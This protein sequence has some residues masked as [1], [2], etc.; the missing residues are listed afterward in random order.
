MP[1][2]AT[3]SEVPLA[4]GGQSSRGCIRREVLG[5]R[6][7]AQ[8]DEHPSQPL[9]RF[10]R[11]G[12]VR[13]ERADAALECLPV[14]GFGLRVMSEQLVEDPEIIHTVERGRMSRAIE[15]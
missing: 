4:E 8:V 15:L 2:A 7:A 6:E 11:T 12:V 1:C 5:F 9:A 13:P 14:E 3:V 10:Q